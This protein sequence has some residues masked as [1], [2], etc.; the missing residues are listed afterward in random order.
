MPQPVNFALMG[1]GG[2]VAP[3]HLQAIRDTGN[4]LVAAMDKHDSVG[5]LDRFFAEV[6]FFI[7]Y[8]R[9]DRHLEKLRRL[10]EDKRVHYLSICTP[11]YL[12]DAHI[13]LALRIQAHAICEKP[14][15]LKPANLD[16]LHVLEQETGKKI[17]NVLQLRLHPAIHALKAKID[18]TTTGEKFEIELTYITARG[19]WYYYA[20]KGDNEKS[21]GIAAN[22]GIHFF[23]MLI[24]I[25][26][27]VQYQEVHHAASSK[28]AGYL[29]LEKARVRWYLSIDKADLPPSI[30][31]THQTTFRAILI[32]QEALEFS[33]GFTDLHT[34]V[35]Q[36]ILAGGGFGLEAARPS[37]NLV[38]EIQHTQP[39]GPNG[40]RSHPFL[41]K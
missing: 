12:H 27:A 10:G 24:W 30:Q 36:D 19:K 39:I 4:Q 38:Y 2:Y 11:N 21:G 22:I 34:L 6:D 17:Y 29:E 26:G 35:Y 33:K 32:N 40:F 16:M 25:F 5:I 9:F 23:D 20:W 41:I 8:E 13:R 15:V 31:Q 1:V 3:R 18:Q 28:A 14:L 7:E 37:L